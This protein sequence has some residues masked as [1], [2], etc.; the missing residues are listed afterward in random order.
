MTSTHSTSAPSFGG[1]A[2][3]AVYVLHENE[4]WMP[5]F[6][7][8]FEAAGVPLVEWEVTGGSLDLTQEPPQGIFWSRMSASSHTRDHGHAKEYTRAV[9][10]WLEAWG[11]TVI[12]GHRVLEIE[13]S[14]VAQYVK[15]AAAGF[16]VPRTVAVFGT[17]DLKERAREFS[18]PFIVKHN[19]GGKGLGVTRF[20]SHHDFHMF[21]DNGF[22]EA[23]VDGVTLVQE[24]LETAEPHISR[25]EFVGGQHVYTVNVDTTGG[26]FQLCPADG[27]ALPEPGAPVVSR[28]TVRPDGA[29]MTIVER[30]RAFLAEQGI[31]IAGI[32]FLETTDGRLVT[33]DI[34]T[35]TNYNPDAEATVDIGGP[36]AIARFTGRLLHEAYPETAGADIPVAPTGRE[37]AHA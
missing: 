22:L 14:K 12:N 28:F 17:A 7:A 25:A 18:A 27:C 26:S 8:A 6:R 19:Q 29:D 5:P 36:L 21:L 33:Y 30:Y 9:L 31:G 16:D 32:E 37:D 24:Y 34:N 13:V 2:V 15:L 1:R 10:D 23:P 3:P 20:D 11:R 4:E 35:N